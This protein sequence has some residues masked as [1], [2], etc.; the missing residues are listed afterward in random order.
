LGELFRLVELIKE[1]RRNKTPLASK[2]NRHL[3]TLTKLL[4]GNSVCTAIMYDERRAQFLISI[5]KM[6]CDDA[7]KLNHLFTYEFLGF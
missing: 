7:S 4:I 3:D 1:S 6:T 5:N 2:E